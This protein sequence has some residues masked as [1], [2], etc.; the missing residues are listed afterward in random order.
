[1]NSPT[2]HLTPLVVLTG[3]LFASPRASAHEPID[4]SCQTTIHAD[5]IE[6][7]S[8]LGMDAARWLFTTA[9]YS[10]EQIKSAFVELGRKKIT[11]HAESISPLLFEVI[12]D[13]QPLP[14]NSVTSISNGELVLTINYSRPAAGPLHLRAMCHKRNPRLRSIPMHV[15]EESGKPLGA[16]QLTA[17]SNELTV[18]LPAPTKAAK[19]AR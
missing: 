15:Y 19:T 4:I 12:A 11:K 17:K 1:M 8:T 3:S 10:P 9:G 5:R 16:A 18:T 7:V 14:T 2:R 13:D 6:V